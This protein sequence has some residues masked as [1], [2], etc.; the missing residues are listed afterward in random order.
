MENIAD[1]PIITESKARLL[2]PITTCLDSG[3]YP[4]ALDLLRSVPVELRD[5]AQVAELE[6]R[7]HDG[8]KRK[9]EADQLITQ[10]QELFAQQKSADAI[11][12]LRKAY[13][14]DK[15]NSLARAILANALVEH[16]QSIVETDWLKSET[17]TNQALALNPA[18]PTAKAVLNKIVERKQTSSV[19]EWVTQARKLQSSGDLF[20]ALAWVAEGLAVHPS[21]TKLIQVQDEIQRDQG[22]RKR[23]ARRGDLDDLRRMEREIAAAKDFAAKHALAE[24]I[25]GLAAKHWTDGEILSIANALLLRLGL[26]SQENSGTPGRGKAATLILHV[27]R[28]NAVKIPEADTSEPLQGTFAKGPLESSPTVPSQASASRVTTEQNRASKCET[29][30][31]PERQGNLPEQSPPN[32]APT[33]TEPPKSVASPVVVPSVA[34]PPMVAPKSAAPAKLRRTAAPVPKVPAASRER[35]SRA[36]QSVPVPVAEPSA[37]AAKA[38]SQSSPTR[39]PAKSSSTV[40]ILVSIS[41]VAMI[42]IA[43]TFFLTRRHYASPET[44]SAGVSTPVSEPTISAPAT[45]VSTASA[46][47]STAPSIPG[48][49]VSTGAAKSEPSPPVSAAPSDASTVRA[50]VA[51]Q[52]AESVSA[53]G[54]L[55]IVAGQDDAQVLLDGKPQRQTTRAGQVRLT[56]LEP[57]DYVVQ[58]SKSGFQNAPQ[59]KIHLRTGETAKLV[60]NLQPQPRLSAL[61]IQGGIPGTAVLVDQATVGT[62]Q[63]DGTLAVSTINPG[64]HTVELRKERFKAK[65]F[66]KAFVAGASVTLTTVDTALETAPGQLKITFTPADANVALVKGTLLKIVS[67]GASLTLE[68]GS[69]MLTARTAERFT[70]SSTVEVVAGQSKT[71]DLS[72]A[73]NGMAKFEDPGAWK[74]EGDSFTRKGGDFVLYGAVPTSGT[75]VFSAMPVKG[76]VLQWVLN[77]TDPRNY[78]LIQMDENNFYRSVM[79][80]GQKT[81]EIIVP[82]KLDKKALRSLQIRVSS[83]EIVHQIKQGESWKVLDH[84]TQLGGD[85][86]RGKFGFYIPGNDQVEISNFAHYADLNLR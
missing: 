31:I 61:T 13:E 1:E 17:L 71:V 11:E 22:A 58:V 57:K 27:P 34:V 49:A 30:L 81:D 14:L 74:H 40:L 73:P 36:P 82:H 69:Y 86:G 16:A 72:L 9:I 78:I 70:R 21:D 5:D 24:R 55:L 35:K 53:T 67:S 26:V 64:D 84:W 37:R 85:L 68:P 8:V 43:A 60:F 4:R 65:Q 3:N 62:V 77:Y 12:F 44:K 41:A 38:P 66:K 52:P 83:T 19:E 63:P 54:T 46:V 80:N 75:F 51:D 50:I 28:P 56:N 29:S 25:Q 10:S 20:G 39:Q 59:Q 23:Q 7:A 6:K 2:E 48:A 47:T 32:E 42:L 45:A 15:R 18:H 76:K 79:R 33:L